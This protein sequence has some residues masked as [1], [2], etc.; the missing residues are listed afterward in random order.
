M[1]D[2]LP[3][4]DK[5]TRDFAGALRDREHPST[6]VL[7]LHADKLMRVHSGKTDRRLMQRLEQ[8]GLA[9]RDTGPEWDAWWLIEAEVA[10]RYMA[11]LA[12]MLASIEDDDKSV[13]DP[14]TDRDGDLDA[15]RR[16]DTAFAE[17]LGEIR[18]ELL[19]VALPSVRGPVSAYDLSHFKNR[20][21]PQLVDFRQEIESRAIAIAREER[22]DVREAMRRNALDGLGNDVSQIERLLSDTPWTVNP[23][24]TL[25]RLAASPDVA[26][27]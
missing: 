23:K 13:M 27:R 11:T 26:A 15:L 2:A 17:R 20:C 18:T 14:V 8:L 24:G 10:R 5:R 9:T 22:A 4:L 25:L 1:V 16:A 3:D 12:R 6:D 21:G 7:R 19:T